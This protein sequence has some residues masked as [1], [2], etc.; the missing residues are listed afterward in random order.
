ME[1][2][3]AKVFPN[4]GTCWGTSLEFAQNGHY[5]LSDERNGK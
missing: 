3:R 1:S 4:A 2:N 5:F